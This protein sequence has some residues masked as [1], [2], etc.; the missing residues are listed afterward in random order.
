MNQDSIF[1]IGGKQYDET[2]TN[3]L[4]KFD[5]KTNE[6][7]VP[8][9]PTRLEMKP[10]SY[11]G[12]IYIFDGRTYNTDVLKSLFLNQFD[13][14]DTINLNWQVGNIVNSPVALTGYTATLVDGIIYYIGGNYFKYS[15]F[16]LFIFSKYITVFLNINSLILQMMVKFM[17]TDYGGSYFNGD[18]PYQIPTKETFVMLNTATLIWS[19]P[20]LNGTNIPKL[21]THDLR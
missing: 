17:C 10:V 16:F 13:I 21:T 14:L 6:L 20:Q 3:Y 12:K 1:I 18:T 9:P 5:T 11:E 2:S 7:S 15:F 4:Y 8:A 19:I